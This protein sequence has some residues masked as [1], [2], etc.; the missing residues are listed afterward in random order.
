[1]RDVIIVGA[2]H[3][4]L[5]C[6]SYLA[7]A[8]LSVLVLERRHVVGGCAVTE[9]FDLEGVGNFKFSRAS[10]LAGLLRPHIVHELGLVE[11][12]G[13]KLIGRDPYSY[14]PSLTPGAEGL[15]L[16]SDEE[17]TKA[18]IARVCSGKDARNFERYEAFLNTAKDAIVPLLDGAPPDLFD[19]RSTMAERWEA[20]KRIV[21]SMRAFAPG[22]RSH[23]F[24][25]LDVSRL[26]TCP[27]KVLLDEWFESDVLKA[28][29][30]TDA[31]IGSMIPPSQP[32]SGYVLLHHVMG[33]ALQYSGDGNVGQS[34]W[35]YAEGGMGAITQALAKSA[36]DAGAT[37]AINSRVKKISLEGSGSDAKASGV[38]LED[39]T[40]H[41]AR[42]VC[43]GCDPYTT[44][45]GLIDQRDT[46]EPFDGLGSFVN[47]VERIDFSCGAAK[48]NLAV[49][50][51]PYF[52]GEGN[53]GPEHRGTIHFEH[54]VQEL[55]LAWQ[56]CSRGLLP[57]Q[58]VI[59]MTIP[60]SLDKTISPEGCHVVQ[61]FVQYVPYS[62]D[63]AAL[64]DRVLKRIEKFSPGFTESILCVDALTPKDL[65]EVF[66]I[67][68]GNIFHGALS[69]HQLFHQR[70][71]PKFSSYQMPIGNLFLCGSG[72]HPG[73]GVSGAPG[74]N[75][76]QAILQRLRQN[77]L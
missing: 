52:G 12:Y 40:E 26:F 73:G 62:C 13:L 31:I 5:T 39:G 19:D 53:P 54:S 44:F 56:Q 69:L 6:A 32:G 68:Q 63:R 11:R 61:L 60:S 71:V 34:S 36:S 50:G 25:A 16:W 7:R 65:E 75:C 38:V 47:Q 76:S 45:V 30:C 77:L 37:I 1:M 74:Y 49:R 24:S 41:R 23:N 15:T 4:A 43:S 58:P 28:T 67:H 46:G 33:E 18:S 72:A 17:K 3:N 66:G 55:E 48:V 57:E 21:K 70:P 9:S 35:C 42:V 8:G 27:A 2:G 10:Y 14:T 29:L 51:L 20:G 64:V 22:K 59:E